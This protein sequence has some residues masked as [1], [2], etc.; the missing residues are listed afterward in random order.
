MTSDEQW[1]QAGLPVK[2][3]GLGLSSAGDLADVAYL[4]SR[5]GTYEDCLALDSGHVWGAGAALGGGRNVV[6]GE[7]LGGCITRVNPL[8][9]DA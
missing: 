4:S 2:Q 1:E 5:D 9:P 3:S 7:W 8:I 6:I